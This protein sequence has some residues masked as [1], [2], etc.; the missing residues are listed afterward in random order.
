[1]TTKNYGA[2]VSGYRDAEGRAWETTVYQAS[3]PILDAELNLVQDSVQQAE[4]RLRRKSLPSGWI[5]EDYLGNSDSTIGIFTGSAV[6]DELRIPQD[7]RAHV[8][9]WMVRVGHTN[10]NGTALN[11]LDLGASPS[12]AGAKRTDLVV[13]EVWRRLLSPAPSTAGKSQTA[14]IWWY[15]NVKIHAADDVGLDFADDIEDVLVGAETTKRVQIQYRLRV[16]QGVDLFA[17]PYGIDDPTVLCNTVPAAP[18]APDGV[19]TAYNYTSQ[20]A[21]GD[22]GLWRAG[23][24]NPANGIGTVDGY[25]YSIPLMAVF[26]RNDTAFDRISNHNGGVASPGPS[27]RPDGLF[28]DIIDEA[29]IE[30]LRFGVSPTGWDLQEVLQKNFNWLLDNNIRAE[31]TSTINGAGV[32]G[33]THLWADEIGVSNANGG[34]PPT[35]GDTTGAEFVGQFDAIRRRF[36]D[37]VTHETVWLEVPPPGATWT[38]TDTVIL[39]PAALPVYPYGAFNWAAYAPAGTHIADVVDL[40]WDDPGLGQCIWDTGNSTPD[41]TLVNISGLGTVPMGAVTMTFT[42]IPATM[43]GTANSLYVQVEIAYP[44]GVGLTKTATEYWD[45]VGGASFSVNNPGQLPAA[46]PIFYNT[47]YATDIYPTWRETEI[48]YETLSHTFTTLGA[49]PIAP[50][51]TI[52]MPER[53]LLVTSV[54]VNAAP[55]PGPWTISSDGYVVTG[56]TFSPGDT[57][58]VTYTAV[59]PYPQ[60]DEQITIYYYA[61]A[62]Q[63]LRTGTLPSPV[64]VLPRYIPSSLWTLICGTGSQDE[65]FP[66]PHQCVQQPGVY[67]SSGG[68]FNGDHDL[69]G[70]SE[71]VLDDW[72]ADVGFIQLPTFVGYVPDPQAA[73]FSRGGG[74]VD[75]EGRSFYK[76]VPPG[77][78]LPSAFGQNFKSK[79]RHRT[80]LPMIVELSADSTIGRKG[81]LFMA[82][83]GCWH[84]FSETNYVAYD[85]T[86]ADNYTSMSLYRL[87]GNLLNR[88]SA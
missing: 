36:S 59:R 71:V 14:L 2:G 85:T 48:T 24:G 8:N 50:A 69:D 32:V 34:T 47:D 83:I 43:I 33:N 46:S 56:A 64:T 63:T 27:D 41:Q 21:A 11:I 18:A 13:L 60:N 10:A 6:A 1:M 3:K 38:G 49:S 61:R 58:V 26:R 72:N 53:V 5:A 39:S 12:G 9:G 86:L 84:P 16:I 22:P 68:A 31:I 74:D 66:F 82:V 73:T 42:G 37:R 77:G 4:I 75:A 45:G 35:T 29:D 87:K 57:L 7:L 51:N 20:S 55:D 52:Y 54:T 19:P 30:D 62:P 76:D 67:P 25:M 80:L 17:Y 65:A 81:Q 70:G 44:S 15:G 28:Y 88:R 79:K 23:D 78:Y 40:W